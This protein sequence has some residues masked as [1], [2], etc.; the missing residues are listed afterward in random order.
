VGFGGGHKT[1]HSAAAARVVRPSSLTARR[2]PLP[3]ASHIQF[4][5]IFTA[6]TSER[7]LQL[8]VLRLGLLQ[9]GDVGVGV[10]PE[11]KKV[12]ISG[13][14]FCGVALYDIGAG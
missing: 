2:H 5:F 1:G 8:G 6:S 12:L 10:F 14:N 4:F 3:P 9:D 7:L 11:G 13:A